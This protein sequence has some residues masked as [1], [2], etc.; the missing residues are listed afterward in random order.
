MRRQDGLYRRGDTFC[1]RW[2]DPKDGAWKEKST[3][4]RNRT[5]AKS[6]KQNFEN[7]VAEGRLPTD[8]RN[9]TVGQACE[10]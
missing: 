6:F 10:K 1:F 3:S 5:E 8:K 9:W 7:D 4:S 2:K